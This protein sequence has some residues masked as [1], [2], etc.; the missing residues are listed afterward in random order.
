MLTIENI[1]ELYQSGVNLEFKNGRHPDGIKG[2]WCLA[3]LEARVYLPAIESE[4]DK[5]ITIIHELL[6][7]RDHIILDVSGIDSEI[8]AEAVLTYEQNPE[9]IE[10]LKD[11]YRFE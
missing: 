8:E 5:N 1:V 2:V 11:I 3:E 7:A 10:F 4:D 6:H 9:I